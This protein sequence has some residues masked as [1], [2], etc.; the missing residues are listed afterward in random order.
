VPTLKTFSVVTGVRAFANED[1]A[2]ADHKKLV[3][4]MLV[5]AST[6]MSDDP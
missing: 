2:D 6:G 3:A 4:P 1:G 5:L